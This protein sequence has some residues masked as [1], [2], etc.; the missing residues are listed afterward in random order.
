M[1]S[2]SRRAFIQ[3]GAMLL[4]GAAVARTA[5]AG[6]DPILRIGLVTDL[7]HADREPNGNRFYRDTLR[8]FA[9][10]ATQFKNEKV[11]L[12]IELG[13][14]ID[15][16]D[17][18]EAEKGYL[19]RIT[20]AFSSVPGQHHYVLGNHCVY[21]L[22]KDEVLDIVRQPKSYYSFDM[23]RHHVVVLDA[24]FR[25]DAEPYGRKNFEWTDA[26]IPPHEVEWLRADIAKTPNKT[27]VFIHQRLDVKDHY[28]VKNA[29]E[30]RAILEG[31]G[32]VP[33]V[34]QGHYHQNDHKE[35]GGIHYCTLAAMIEG[36]FPNNAYAVMDILPNN[37]IHIRGFGKQESYEFP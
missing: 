31:S 13:D 26:N 18:P 20:S 21:S 8:K 5:Q 16:A 28:G 15:A 3:K 7:H 25:S 6:D 36:P 17:S 22:S 9:R 37:A 14:S 10:A 34:L 33:L 12:V 23:K 19:K 4:T 35:I 1:N 30:I 24:C 11:D 2:L 27:L 29:S 32:K